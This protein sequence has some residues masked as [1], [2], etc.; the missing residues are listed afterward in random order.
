MYTNVSSCVRSTPA[1][2]LTAMRTATSALSARRKTRYASHMHR[3]LTGL[4]FVHVKLLLT[5]YVL[6]SL[7]ITTACGSTTEEDA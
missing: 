1:C 7:A 4:P 5:K 3:P 2:Q 6:A